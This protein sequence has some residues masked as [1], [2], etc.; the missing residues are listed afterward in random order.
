MKMF[1]TEDVVAGGT[2]EEWA[3]VAIIVCTSCDNVGT[4][5][6]TGRLHYV[7][8]RPEGKAKHT[9]ALT[10]TCTYSHAHT[11]THILTHSHTHTHTCTHSHTHTCTHTHTHTLTHT[12]T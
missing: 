6:Y 5:C 1:E 4:S 7:E 10:H 12:H 3:H 11:L 2:D 9:H 8:S